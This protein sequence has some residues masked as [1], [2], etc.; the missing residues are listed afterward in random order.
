ML[1]ALIAAK[2]LADLT[3]ARLEKVSK[4]AFAAVPLDWANEQVK[5]DDSRKIA[6]FEDPNC[7]YCKRLHQARQNVDNITVY[8]LLFP[9]LSPDSTVKARN[10]WCAKDQAATWRAWMLNGKT[11]PEAN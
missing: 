11:P 6:V 3:G 2:S 1:G 10:I 7:G 9:I 8:T 5:G 4:V